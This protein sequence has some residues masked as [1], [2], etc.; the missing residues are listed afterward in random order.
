MITI[1]DGYNTVDIDR[2]YA[3]LPAAGEGGRS[4]E[5]LEEYCRRLGAKVVQAGFSYNSGKNAHFLT[6]EEIRDLIRA[7]VNP[8]FRH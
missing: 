7:H 4:S 5:I 2:Y 8:D 3:I 1:N 6:V